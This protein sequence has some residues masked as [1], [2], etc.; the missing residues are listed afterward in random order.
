MND[1][2]II[3]QSDLP[4]EPAKVKDENVFLRETKAHAEMPLVKSV[5]IILVIVCIT[6]NIMFLSKLRD[7][8]LPPSISEKQ[9]PE[10]I[11]DTKEP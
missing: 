4:Q 1:D 3:D 6:L 9:K 7:K 5:S 2:Y 11:K 10:E 8:S